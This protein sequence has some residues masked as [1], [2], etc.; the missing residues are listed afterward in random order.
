M[1]TGGSG[2]MAPRGFWSYGPRYES[3]QVKDRPFRE[4][5]VVFRDSTLLGCSQE[6]KSIYRRDFAISEGEKFDP[7]WFAKWKILSEGRKGG[8]MWRSQRL[9]HKSTWSRGTSG[10]LASGAPIIAMALTPDA[11]FLADSKGGLAAVSPRDGSLLG[12][13]ALRAP[14][15]D[16][17]AAVAGRLLLT[18]QQGQ[19]VCLAE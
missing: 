5:L 8:D 15:W 11:L 12:R 3:E 18:T 9:A 19:V 10:W 2:V 13:A 7:Q 4:P 1:V 16:G 14:A 17:M 6:R